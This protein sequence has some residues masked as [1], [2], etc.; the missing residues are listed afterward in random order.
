MKK[1]HLLILSILIVAS[2]LI[3]AFAPDQNQNLPGEI[4]EEI[5]K[6]IGANSIIYTQLGC[7]ACKAQEELFG[8]Y[9]KYLNEIDCIFEKQECIEAEITATPTWVI[10]GKY[11]IGVKQIGALRELTG[12]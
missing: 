5:A 7:H 2:I 9:Y 6:C 3:I 1:S 8:D 10:D 11:Y 12:C 4:N